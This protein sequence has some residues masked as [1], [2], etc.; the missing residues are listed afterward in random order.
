MPVPRP[1][2]FE[3]LLA[4]VAPA[5]VLL[6]SDFDGTLSP[7]VDRPERAR[8]LPAA[9]DA[10]RRLVP[11]LGRLL[12][13]SGRSNVDLQRFLP[14]EG[15]DLRGDYG[16]GLPT[17]EELSALE[18]VSTELGEFLGRHPGTWL[19]R[20]P[21]S[22]TVHYRDTPAAAAEVSSQVKSVAAA[23]GLRARDGRMVVE[24]MPERADKAASLGAEVRA[25]D[26]AAVIF[27]GDDTGDRGCF[28]LVATLPL[29]HLAVGVRS[30]EADPAI[31]ERCDLVVEG[32]PAWADLLTQ[33]ADW[34]DRH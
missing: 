3:L 14:I 4:G 9:L 17:A 5:T 8:A 24:L 32:P 34:A 27:A 29:P 25:F 16:L 11:K 13:V 15:L 21:G 22:M 30:P 26:P 19:E 33:L 6:A 1:Y 31:F 7:I 12:I 23:R 28:E 10:L 2:P 18:S 20:K